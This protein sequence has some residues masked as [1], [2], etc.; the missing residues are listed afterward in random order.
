MTS[1]LVLSALGVDSATIV[2]DFL[3]S[4]AYMSI[5]NEAQI[6]QINAAY[7]AGVGEKL[8]PVLGVDVTYIQAFFTAVNRQYGSMSAFLVA[9]G[10]DTAKMRS[11]YLE[12]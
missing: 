9:L 10:V 2:R 6:A 1:A 8:R 11:L 3:K 5:A 7:G 12:K 4:N